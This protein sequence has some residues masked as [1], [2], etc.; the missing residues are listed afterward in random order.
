MHFVATTCPI[1]HLRNG[2]FMLHFVKVKYGTNS[3]Q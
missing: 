3:P 2:V 1:M